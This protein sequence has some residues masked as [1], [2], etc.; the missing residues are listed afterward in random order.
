[1]LHD[2]DYMREPE[3]KPALPATTTLLIINVVV[4]VLQSILDFYKIFPV[5]ARLGLSLEGLRQGFVWQLVSFQFLHVGLLHLVVN[6]ITIWF[7]GRAMEDTLGRRG[8]WQLYFS[9]GVMGGLLQILAAWMLPGHFGGAVVGASAGAFGLVAAYAMMFPERQLTLLVFFVIPV[10]LRA[11]TLLWIS[12]GLALFGI[13]VPT[14]NVAHAAHLGGMLTGLAFVRWLVLADGTAA[15]LRPFRR[16]E[17]VGTSHKGEIMLRRPGRIP[18]QEDLPPTE[19]ISRE[20]DPILDKIS[21]H[22]IQSLTERERRVLEAAR[23][24]MGKR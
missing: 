15:L 7:F 3:I 13:V 21:A 20:V 24:R 4:F 2:R 19:F 6:S 9:S 22:G 14:D 18:P 23:V 12:F 5:E 17:L 16:R 1:M 10:S 11:K 8:F